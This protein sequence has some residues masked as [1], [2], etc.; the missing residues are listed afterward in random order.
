[1]LTLSISIRV[2]KEDI[3]LQSDQKLWT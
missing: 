2:Q 1:M 3:Q